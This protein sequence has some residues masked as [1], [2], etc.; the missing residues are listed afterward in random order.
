MH[1]VVVIGGGPAGAVTARALV[2]QGRSVVLLEEHAAVGQPVHCTGLVGLE[3]F[4][5]FE[6]P[7][8][9]ILGFADAARFLGAAGESV[10]VHSP[11]ARAAVIDRAALDVH[12][13]DRAERAG[14]DVRRGWRAETVRVD[15]T[16]VSVD[17]RDGT[18]LRARAC[19]LACG[20]NYRFHKALGLGVPKVFLQ[21]AQV[22]TPFPDHPEV[23]VRFGR[24]VAPAGFAWLVPLRREGVPH[25]RIGLMAET[26]S[27]DRFQ[28]FAGALTS[29][30]G[31]PADAIP[32]PKLKMLPLAPVPQTYADRVLA[33]GDA[34][35]LVKPTTGGGIYYGMLSGVL[36]ADVLG[37][38]LA[39]D[40]LGARALRRY[41]T[42]W[43]KRLGPDIRAGL[44]FRR[45]TSGLSDDSID[46]L[47]DL[48]RVNGVVPILQQT[49][50]FNW[51]RKAAIALLADP[52]FRRIVFRS[53]RE[54]VG[55]L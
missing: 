13:V 28:R 53:L 54:N 23:Q 45:F 17:G 38:A 11:R 14:A 43:R 50:S 31:L 33:V 8:T 1:D 7:R 35:G 32:A 12:L 15:G 5:E 20:A 27:R 21:S 34:A 52:S 6:L 4:E 40:R 22:E 3:A 41:E 25:A 10:V 47:I 30:L 42:S 46:Q 2:E 24:D 49:A 18:T 26:R 29:E 19:V 44:A 48:A 39:T 16:G 36:A 55:L 9:L 37:D 51:H